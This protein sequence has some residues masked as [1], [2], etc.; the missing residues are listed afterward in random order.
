MSAS[1]GGIPPLVDGGE[2]AGSSPEERAGTWVRIAPQSPGTQQRLGAHVG[3]SGCR[4][5]PD[6][7]R[8]WRAGGSFSRRGWLYIEL[9]AADL[10]PLSAL[11]DLPRGRA[12][13]LLE[14]YCSAVEYLA[15]KGERPLS[16]VNLRSVYFDETGAF[17][18]LPSAVEEIQVKNLPDEEQRLW[19]QRW[20][21]SGLQGELAAGYQA[22]AITFGILTG[23]SPLEDEEGV[24][25][26]PHRLVPEI[27]EEPAEELFRI[28]RGEIRSSFDTVKGLISRFRSRELMETLTASERQQ[29]YEAAE[30]LYR[31]HY[32]S[33]RRS[34]LVKRA[35][36]SFV[37]SVVIAG[38]VLLLFTPF[39]SGS[40]EEPVTA[41]RSPEEV[42]RIFYESHNDLGH[43]VM[44]ECT[45]GGAASVH[46]REVTTLFVIN[47]IRRGVEG[48]TPFMSVQTWKQQGRPSPGRDTFV[49]GVDELTIEPAGERRYT[50]EYTKYSTLPPQRE[51]ETA[52]KGSAVNESTVEEKAKELESTGRV[53]SVRI[54][55]E[56]LMKETDEGWKIDRIEVL[57]RR[58]LQ[59]S[60]E[61]GS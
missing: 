29:R 20:I 14:R 4:I 33:H 35:A 13:E 25:Q 7:Y 21:H 49:Y 42:I 55:E 44:S 34:R 38:A 37:L 5:S 22:A 23:A 60:A 45:T 53:R 17:Y 50:A 18:F 2:S 3:S 48:I 9:P 12:L 27:A 40:R 46:M 41:G 52:E 47:R 28:L 32:R 51:S 11:F 16:A 43:T 19:H 39:L 54:R 57:E 36:P 1:G 10:Q 15:E 31:R 8:R 58:N 6:E 30:A 24:I 26:H 56:L 61:E 59:N